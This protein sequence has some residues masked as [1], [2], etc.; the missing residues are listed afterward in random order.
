MEVVIIASVRERLL[1]FGLK[2][3]NFVEP[4]AKYGISYYLNRELKRYK[5]EGAVAAYRVK[6]KRLSRWQYKIEV[7]LDVTSRQLA[8][9]LA[10]LTQQVKNLVGR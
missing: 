5:E 8:Y 6:T 3:I 2:Y 7:D 10:Q 9:L 1:Q 4:F